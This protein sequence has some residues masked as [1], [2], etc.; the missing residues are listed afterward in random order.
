M[1]ERYA[2]ELANEIGLLQNERRSAI[3]I[4]EGGDD[5]SLMDKFVDPDQCRIVVAGNK[6]NVKDV[7][8]ELERRMFDGFLGMVDADFDRILDRMPTSPNIVMPDGHDAE[9]MVIR[10]PAI[11][12]IWIEFG[13]VKKLKALD[14][15]PYE[16]VDAIAYQMGCLR[17]HS[18]RSQIGLKFEG[19]NVSKFVNAAPFRIDRTKFV[20]EIKN[21]SQSHHFQNKVMVASIESVES[22]SHPTEQ[23]SNGKDFIA[24]LSYG[25]RRIFGSNQAG[26]VSE[27]NIQ[28]A[29][30]LAYHISD[31]EKSKLYSDIRRWESQSGS[32]RILKEFD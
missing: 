17:L 2:Y 32:F 11:N 25:L 5:Q 13:S 31:F 8:D 26:V 1:L 24:V 22:E 23:L 12:G 30:R 20:I 3:L 19:M 9:S 15:D 6:R 27:D 14:G 28:M 21:R 10:S 16:L 4:V 29:L 7:V 18:F